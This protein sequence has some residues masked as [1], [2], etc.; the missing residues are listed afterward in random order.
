MG[1][2]NKAEKVNGLLTKLNDIAV[3][4]IKKEKYEKAMAAISSSAK[5]QYM[6]NQRYTDSKLER[7]IVEI[8]KREKKKYANDISK[9]QIKNNTVMFYDGFGLD[10]RGV[11]IMYLNALA[12]NNY[13]IIYV[14]KQGV[15]NQQPEIH[16]ILKTAKVT[17][18]YIPIRQ[19]Y[20]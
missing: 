4:A 17:W 19:S 6:Y 10:T 9:M 16:E 8:A 18:K 14:T 15:E 2:S 20:S 11:A 3:K 12:K 13:H 1:T 5:I 7:D